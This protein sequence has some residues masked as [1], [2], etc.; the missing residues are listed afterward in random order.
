LPVVGYSQ[1]ILWT[2][3]FDNISDWVL[4]NSCTY[5]AYNIVGGYDYVNQ[6]QISSTSVCTGSGT[7]AVDPNTGASAQWKFETDGNLIPVVD[8]A[9]FGSSSVS[10]GFLFIDSDACGGADGDG[11][12]IF[13]TAT[14]ATP[15]DLSAENNVVLSFSHNYRWWQDTRGVRVSGD[16][17]RTWYQYEITNNSGYPNDQNSGNPEITDIDISSVA[18]GQSQV[19]IQFYYE[20]NDFWA[21]FW[22]VDDVKILRKEL[23]NYIPQ[24]ITC[25]AGVQYDFL[26]GNVETGTGWTGISASGNQTWRFGSGGT[27]SGS[28]GPNGANSG[29]S[30]FYFEAT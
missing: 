27:P 30:Y 14:T 21:W 6:T 12:P 15:I 29:T 26:P 4:D 5:S 23:N 25:S 2:N 10:N 3:E 18:G 16:S 19:L 11:T 1:T 9:P 24:G 28:T 7:V 8:L 13:V 20:D 22:A 17:G